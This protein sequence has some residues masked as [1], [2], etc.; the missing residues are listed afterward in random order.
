MGASLRPGQ[1]DPRAAALSRAAE[2][3][4]VAYDANAVETQYLQGWLMYDRFIL[5]DPFGAPYEFLW[6]NPYQ[7]GLSYFHVPLLWHDMLAGL[8]FARSSWEDSAQWFGYFQGVAQWF[9]QG[10]VTV[11]DPRIS[12]PVTIGD[13]TILFPGSVPAAIRL[14]EDQRAF[15]VGLA[16]GAN[17][18]LEIDGAA[19]GQVTS[20]PGGMA[21]LQLP[22]GRKIK[23]RL[24]N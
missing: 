4:M 6:A 21:E 12:A 9:D 2:L 17:Y 13:A 1:P 18:T 19:H 23:V 8:L 5:R 3:A 15:A 10:R 14:D 20:A 24:R 11:L 7:P 16:P 22:S